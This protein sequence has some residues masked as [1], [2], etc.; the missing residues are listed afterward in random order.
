MQ[1][2]V[3]GQLPENVHQRKLIAAIGA[4]TLTNAVRHAGA[5]QLWI[6]VEENEAAYIIRYTNDGDVPAGPVTE[7]GGLSTARRKIEAAGG[8][9]NIAANPRFMLTIIFEKGVTMDV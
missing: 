8:K 6:S 2:H 5:K 1:V 4:E 9:M 7:G 3:S